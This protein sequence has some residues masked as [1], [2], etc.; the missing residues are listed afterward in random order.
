MIGENQWFSLQNHIL[1]T[2]RKCLLLLSNTNVRGMCTTIFTQTFLYGCKKLVRTEEKKSRVTIAIL[3]QCKPSG[4]GSFRQIIKEVKTENHTGAAKKLFL[5]LIQYTPCMYEFC[6]QYITVTCD[7]NSCYSKKRDLSKEF[8]GDKTVYN[9][10]K[11]DRKQ[12]KVYLIKH[13]KFSI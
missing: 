11:G 2:Q 6:S 8:L 4:G 1:G 3:L 9:K 7:P 10:S 12:S 5:H 13:V